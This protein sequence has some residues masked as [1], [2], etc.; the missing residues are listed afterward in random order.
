[1]E[2]LKLTFRTLLNM[3]DTS[4]VRYLQT[5]V[6]WE[7]R[8]IAIVGARGTGKTTLLLQHIKL[9]LDLN[10]T[11]FVNADDFYFAN[12]KLFH[13]AETFSRNG[14]THLFIDEVHKYADWSREIK[15]MY[16]F[17]PDLKVVFTGSSILDIYKGQADLSRRVILYHLHGLSFREY[18]NIKLKKQYQPFT[19]EQVLAHQVKIYEKPLPHFKEY[20]ETG[21]YPFFREGKYTERLKNIINQTLEVDIPMFTD[22]N[23]STARKL[24]QLLYII[25][26]SVPFK[27]NYTK[28][29]EQI[30]VHRNQVNDYMVYLEQAGLINR[31]LDGSKGLQQLGKVQKVYLNNTNMNRAIG[32]EN[33][34]LGNQRETFFFNQVKLKMPVVASTLSDFQVGD[35][36]FEVG[37]KNKK[38]TQIKEAANGMVV[39][40]DIEYGISNILPLWQFGMMY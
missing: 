8:V 5:E 27:P 26:E 2:T 29:G 38:Q 1:M 23:V 36:T 31:L 30:G 18:L 13:L 4:F 37:G 9:N 6:D 14:G 11:L 39:K 3:T 12:T 10:T 32:A 28:I 24:K 15:M 25:A 7:S 17:L 40:D 35:Y 20:L 22:M 21:Y 33:Y 19:F 34:N 16:D